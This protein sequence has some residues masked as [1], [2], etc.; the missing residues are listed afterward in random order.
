MV[1]DAIYTLFSSGKNIVSL[2]M[3]A[4]TIACKEVS[5][6]KGSSTK[7]SA[8][9]KSI[10]KLQGIVVSI[11]Y[12]EIERAK[13]NI[14]A[15]ANESFVIEGTLMP[16]TTKI[17][18]SKVKHRNKTVYEILTK[19]VLYDYAEQLG[20]IIKVPTSVLAIDGIREDD[21]FLAIKQQLVKEIM[22]MKNTKNKYVNRMIK[23]EWANGDRGGFA[24]RVGLKK[25]N[26]SNDIQWNKRKVKLTNQLKVIFEH[27]ISVKFIKGYEPIKDGKSVVGFEIKI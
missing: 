9:R 23:Y 2:E 4:N 1:M 20:R 15:D 7:L 14:L 16:V 26:Y 5:L 22:I 21:D 12:T 19:P 27:L 17:R 10:L 24:E 18:K 6:D 25:E 3:V 11:D 8:I 13:G